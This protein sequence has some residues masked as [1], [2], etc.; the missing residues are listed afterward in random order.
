MRRLRLALA[1]VLDILTMYGPMEL[2][3][4]GADA[5]F[6]WAIRGWWM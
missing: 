1:W 4:R 5:L 3:R 6:M 2:V